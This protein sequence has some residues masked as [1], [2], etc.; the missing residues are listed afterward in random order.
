MFRQQKGLEMPVNLDAGGQAVRP[1]PEADWA[2]VWGLGS[3]KPDDGELCVFQAGLR[4]AS[5]DA[6]EA[7]S[8][9]IPSC[10][11]F[12]CLVSCVVFISIQ[13]L[14]RGRQVGE[15]TRIVSISHCSRMHPASALQDV[16]EA[17]WALLIA[18]VYH[19]EAGT[20]KIP[21]YHVKKG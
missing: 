12:G 6:T 13:M 4:C 1:L 10:S 16:M 20:L 17:G 15:V 5:P 18:M 3:A 21:T 19:A 14:D 11:D 7:V 8:L 9:S 2:S